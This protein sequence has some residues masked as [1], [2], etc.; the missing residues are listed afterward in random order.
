MPDYL[1]GNL[2]SGEWEPKGSP[3]SPGARITDPV[4]S[5][6]TV[7]AI[8]KDGSLQHQILLCLWGAER[9]VTD[10]EITEY[11]EVRYSRRF[12][13]NVVARARL[14]LERKDLIMR[15]PARVCTVMHREAVTFVKA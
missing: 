12:Q 13:R 1:Q 11:L 10:G 4:T 9:P 15:C 14:E 3:P 8:V 7:A 6:R 5:Q 2:I